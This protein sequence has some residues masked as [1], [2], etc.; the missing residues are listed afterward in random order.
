MSSQTIIDSAVVQLQRF[1]PFDEIP[2]AQLLPFARALTIQFFAAGEI[3]LPAGRQASEAI[4]VVKAGSVREERA[5]AGGAASP[6]TVFAPGEMFPIGEVIAELNTHSAFRAVEDSFVYAI[7]AAQFRVFLAEIPALRDFCERQIFNL[8]E[9]SRTSLRAAYA[10]QSLSEHP[11]TQSIA[12]AIKRAPVTCPI[13]TTIGDAL[14]RMHHEKIGAIVLVDAQNCAAGIL[15]ERDLIGRVVLPNVALTSPAI[16]VASRPVSTLDEQQPMSAAALMMVTKNFRHVVVTR[17]G[18]VSGVVSERNL[19]ALQRRSLAAVTDAIALAPDIDSLVRAAADIRHL[20]RSLVAQG[21][22]AAILTQ[23]ISQLNDQLTRRMLEILARSH[24][25]STDSHVRWCWL[26]F[27]SEGRHEQTISTDQDN[28]LVFDIVDSAREGSTVQFQRPEKSAVRSALVQFALAVNHALARCG[29]PL[30]KG[31]IMASNPDLCLSVEEWVAKFSHWID[32]GDPQSLLNAN[33]FFDMR[34]LQ[35]DES[36]AEGITRPVALL[37]KSNGRFRKQMADNALTH[38][39]ALNLIGRIDASKTGTIDIKRVGA[40]PF[41]DGARLLA[42]AAGV[43][44]TRTRDRLM[45][46][47]PLLSIPQEEIQSWIEAF[48]FVQMLRLRHQHANLSADESGEGVFE[49]A[50]EIVVAT[51]STLDHR[52]LREAFHQ[53]RRLQHRIE[54]DYQ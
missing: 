34:P 26:A 41:T 1:A 48:E 25:I 28:G 24:P 47:G 23:L 2:A 37:A 29:Y 38:Q 44:A 21:V 18:K 32:A 45:E 31:N 53:A 36:L 10:A 4:F 8:L 3:A 13:D 9:R 15:T 22:T 42:L 5:A 17:D 54:L 14:A 16:L 49:N 19:F 40:M 52:I 43:R 7:P 33:I 50:N 6:A 20:S 46:V 11:F 30:C 35:G 12:S 27:G 39:P 51:L